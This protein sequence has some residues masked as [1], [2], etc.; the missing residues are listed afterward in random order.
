MGLNNAL[1]QGLMANLAAV[2]ILTMVWV[3]CLQITNRWSKRSQAVAFGCFMGS[4]TLLVM[5]MPFIT[6]GGF[7]LDHRFT[8]IG[9]AGLFGGPVAL[10]I[11]AGTAAI[12]RCYVGGAATMT[13]LI[14][15]AV[16]TL[17]ALALHWLARSTSRTNWHVIG[18]SLAIPTGVIAG[19]FLLPRDLWPTARPDVSIPLGAT[20]CLATLISGLALLREERR[21]ALLRQN[22]I[23]E[24]IINALPDCLNVKDME[25]RFIAAN[26]AT[27]DLMLAGHPR[28]LIGKTDA[29]FYPKDIAQAFRRDELA[30]MES[31]QVAPIEQTIRR[32]DGSITY[33]STL[34]APLY[35]IDG[36]KIGLITHN[37]DITDKRVLQDDLYKVRR[38]LDD[39]ITNMNDGLAIYDR[40]GVMIYCNEQY[41]SLFPLTADLRKP[42]ARLED[43]MKA[44]LERGERPGLL[45]G[46]RDWLNAVTSSAFSRQD[47]EMHLCDDRWM[48]VKSVSVNDGTLL[49]VSDITGRKHAEMEVAA[50]AREYGAL[51]E[52]SVAGIF[53][54]T[55]N[56]RM[57][58]ANPALARLNGCESEAELISLVNDIGTE[59]YVDPSRRLEFVHLMGRDGRVTDFVSEVYRFKTREPIWISETAWTV[60]DAEGRAICYEG[61]ITEITDRKHA[62]QELEKTNSKLYSLSR[63]DGLTGLANR[64]AFDDCIAS[65]F[66]RAKSNSSPLSVLLIDVDHFK[67]FNDNYGHV[68]GDECLR[69]IARAVA[70]IPRGYG[71]K[72]CRYGGEEMSVVLPDTD[73]ASA[74]K[75]A[76]KLKSSIN[77]LRIAHA[78]SEEGIV[79]VSI[80]VATASPASMPSTVEQLIEFADRAL[81]DAKRNGRNRVFTSWAA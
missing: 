25:G 71:D 14:G 39:A 1:W 70:T 59:W 45:A 52:N 23:H 37:R 42:G 56:G 5:Q 69:F 40:A 74:L 48:N 34:K 80:G 43:I 13:G 57:L 6:S 58:R 46:N 11:T 9:I 64:R 62:E 32:A 20:I 24:A 38:T 33:L 66:D 17:I 15:I 50:A 78:A 60:T 31:A 75:L 51:F 61:T 47:D 16:S 12:Y 67:K 73:A 79:T 19:L 30:A 26:P 44:S 77:S 72:A 3:Q 35:D 54:S 28:H 53:R 27:A 76:E 55:V 49:L 36:S 10:A 81:Y 8:L 4:A 68:K 7:R 63:T 29:D 41:R 21:L 22:A 2:A 65:E 18:L